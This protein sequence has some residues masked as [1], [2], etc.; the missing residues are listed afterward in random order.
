MNNR[1]IILAGGLSSRMKNSSI[2]NDL[3]TKQIE[4]ANERSKGLIEIDAAGNTL[5]DYLLDNTVKSGYKIVYIV[6][7]NDGS[8]FRERF[9]KYKKL[10]IK[11]A[12]QFIPKNREKPWGTAD[13]VFQTMVQY[14]ELQQTQFSV[15]NSDNLYT[16]NALRQLRLSESKNTCIA[17]DRSALNFSKERVSKFAIMQFDEAYHL[18]NIREKPDISKVD[19]F[20]DKDGKIRIS[21]NI[22]AFDGA[23]SFPFFKN[24][25]VHPQRQEKEIPTVIAN[26]L[27][28][29]PE[30]MVGIPMAEHVPDLTCKEDIIKMTAFLINNS[31][32]L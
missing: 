14:P 8:L 27:K 22:F 12:T 29:Y 4:Q 17:Y 13:A 24:C 31:N 11:F 15:C 3:N 1:L 28:M 2:I 16:L 32:K 23:M 26:M 7:S 18:I 25:P 30:S 10:E 6:T 19:T 21:M 20:R 5:L 9:K